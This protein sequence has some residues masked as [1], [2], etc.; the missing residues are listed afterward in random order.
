MELDTIVCGDCLDVMAEI[1]N[2]CVDLIVTSP[3]YNC[4][5]SYGGFQDEIPWG[6]WYGFMEMFLMKSLRIMRDGAVMA[7]NLPSVI[8]WQRDH[9]FKHT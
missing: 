6:Q 7:L 8:R 1:P 3:Y 5:K 9:A 2:E 4:R